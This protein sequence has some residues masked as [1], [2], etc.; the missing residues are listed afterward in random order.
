MKNYPSPTLHKYWA[1]NII[2]YTRYSFRLNIQ[3]AD[4][5]HLMG[6]QPYSFYPGSLQTQNQI[7]ILGTRATESE[8]GG[9]KGSSGLLQ[10]GSYRDKL[11][12]TGWPI[13]LGHCPELGTAS[14]QASQT[15]SSLPGTLP[16]CPHLPNS[17]S[18]THQTQSG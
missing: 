2:M 15:G 7:P 17:P 13:R 12:P 6:P 5:C 8:Q 1:F 16:L 4:L 14:R 3:H 18:P 11:L 10:Q 9:F